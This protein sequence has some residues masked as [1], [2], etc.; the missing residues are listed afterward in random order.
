MRVVTVMGAYRKQNE[1]G[2]YERGVGRADGRAGLPVIAR[3]WLVAPHCIPDV[4]WEEIIT[5]KVLGS[6]IDET[7]DK[8]SR[9]S[10]DK[11]F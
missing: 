6:Q 10:I 7:I 2:R 11:L 9:Y 1:D 8:N 5:W 4:I 3:Q